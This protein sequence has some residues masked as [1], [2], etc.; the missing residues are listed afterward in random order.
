M[1]SLFYPG[2]RLR[3]EP[4]TSRTPLFPVYSAASVTLSLPAGRKISLSARFNAMVLGKFH[5][6]SAPLN[7]DYLPLTSGLND[8]TGNFLCFAEETPS[9]DCEKSTCFQDF[10]LTLKIQALFLNNSHI[11]RSFSPFSTV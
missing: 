8:R 4:D 1:M 9:I 10:F 7:I 3:L 5:I 6:K 11:T 2:M